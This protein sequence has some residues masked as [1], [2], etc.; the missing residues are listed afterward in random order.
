[1]SYD[2]YINGIGNPLHPENK[3]EQERT[4]EDVIYELKSDDKEIIFDHIQTIEFKANQKHLGFKTR[5]E[6]ALDKLEELKSYSEV[7]DNTYLKSRIKS[8]IKTL[9][10]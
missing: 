7:T 9:N 6:M 3:E 2:F 5:A 10:P 1:M 4:F 8:I